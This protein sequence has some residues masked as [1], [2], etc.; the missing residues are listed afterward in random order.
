MILILLL[1]GLGLRM[2]RD[3]PAV[4]TERWLLAACLLIC[5]ILTRH[6]DGLLV[7][8]FPVLFLL[9]ACGSWR[10]MIALPFSFTPTLRNFLAAAAVGLLSILLASAYTNALCR[11]A[12]V[13]PRSE[14]GFT[15]LWRLNFLDAMTPGERA[16][17]L[18]QTARRTMPPD[19]RQLVQFLRVWDAHH[20]R[21][22][23]TDFLAAARTNL[24]FA[25]G[26]GL[27]PRFDRALN[28]T[29]AAFFYPPVR[30]LRAIAARDFLAGLRLTEGVIARYLFTTTAYLNEHREPTPQLAGLTTFRD[31]GAG[32]MRFADVPYFR[33]WDF[34]SVRVWCG[35]WLGISLLLWLAGR[36]SRRGEFSTLAYA[37]ML[38]GTG[39]LMTFV[40]CCLAQLIPRFALPMLELLLLSI[41]VLLGTLLALAEVIWRERYAIN[42][43]AATSAA[44]VSGGNLQTKGDG[45][46]PTVR[47]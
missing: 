43:K 1:V 12:R 14:F 16:I 33:L 8:L 25:A 44:P 30:P 32:F 7:A 38:A 21:W 39:L 9:L 22:S 15:F 5:C 13:V 42:D 10:E 31:P 36:K 20:P 41:V 34:L 3:H 40:N 27:T 23:P 29:A 37:A 19:S 17:L 28:D 46:R 2:V 18:E 26:A 6:I 47:S 24:D 45:K 35:I 11:N 4:K